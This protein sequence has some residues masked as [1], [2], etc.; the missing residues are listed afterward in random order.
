MSETEKKTPL[1]V[2][3]GNHPHTRPLKDG[4]VS[5]DGVDCHYPEFAPLPPAFA[6]MV[7]ELA[8]DICEMPMATY[9]Q[10]RDAG[11]PVTLLPVVLVGSTHHRSLTR[12]P[13]GEALDPKELVGRRVGVRSYGQTTGL[14]VRG[15]LREEY[16]VDSSDVTW[17]TTEDV[18]V[19][20]YRNPANVERSDSGRVADLLRAGDVSAAV[21][22]PKAIGGQGA[23]LVPLVKDAEDAGQA[24]IERHGTVPA[25]HL[26]VVR[27]DILR[28]RED[29]VTAVYRALRDA[30]ASTAGDRDGS[31]AGRAV[32]AGWSD[33]LAACLEIA[34]QY[35]LE[36]GLIGE[37]VDVAAIEEKAA[38]LAR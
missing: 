32:T 27:D 25:N 3:L 16:G 23:G 26:L 15:W 28:D 37:P 1:S 2:V 36:Q 20:Q 35:A 31:P 5:V 11:V 8:Y 24:W 19:A 4:I 33:S 9:L 10:A 34:G 29:E 12:L 21:L 13:E 22:G 6:R 7:R 17:V 18:H 30:I 38:F 14:W